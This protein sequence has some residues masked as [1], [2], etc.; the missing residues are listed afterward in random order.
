M[1][2]KIEELKYQNVNTSRGEAIKINIISGGKKYSCFKG[3]W[4]SDWTVGQEIDVEIETKPGK[5]PGQLYHNI[6]TPPS[7]YN[8][9]GLTAMIQELSA[10]MD[11]A[12]AA[13]ESLKNNNSQEKDLPF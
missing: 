1:K 4:N 13:I 12:L 3:K 7:A 9:S 5:E 8:N 10:K 6:K 2:L 11:K